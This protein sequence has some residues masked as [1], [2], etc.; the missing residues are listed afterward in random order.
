M[1]LSEFKKRADEYTSKA[2]EITRQLI[3][4]GIAIIWI[5]RNPNGKLDTLLIYPLTFLTIALVAD[6]LQYVLGGKVWMDFFRSEEAR[7]K[8]KNETDPEIKAPKKLSD[9]IYLCYWLK[10]GL[11]FFSYLLLIIYLIRFIVTF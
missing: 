4:A 8:E 5:F 9:Y 2:S 1:R 3:F 10:I 7:A 6:L 11:M